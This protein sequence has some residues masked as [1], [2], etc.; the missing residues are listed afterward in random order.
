VALPQLTAEQRLAA[1]DKAVAARR[2]R[3][4]LKDQLKR[5]ET[6]V[7]QVLD[8]AATDEVIAKL[9]VSELLAALPGIGDVTA[10]DIMIELGIAPSRRLRGLGDH[11]RHALLAK[12]DSTSGN[13]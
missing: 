1:L 6:T 4:A 10:L 13:R 12:F 2:A 11:Q 7:G 9:R 3:A 5:G 8:E